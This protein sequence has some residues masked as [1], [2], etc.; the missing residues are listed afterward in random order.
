MSIFLFF[1]LELP[2]NSQQDQ[3]KIS[4]IFSLT[5]SWIAPCILLRNTPCTQD[6]LYP[7]IFAQKIPNIFQKICRLGYTC[8]FQF[9]FPQCVYPAVGLLGNMAVLFSVFKLISTLLSIMPV[10][11]CS[12]TNSVRGFPFLHTLSSIYYLQT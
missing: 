3:K 9:W 5:C 10:L 8:L 1:F 12:P 7:Y 6:N 2:T 11:V 4:N